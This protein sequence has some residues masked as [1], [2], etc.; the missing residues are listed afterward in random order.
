MPSPT[1]VALATTT[2]GS[3]GASSITFSS[4]PQTYTDLVV[5]ASVRSQ[6]AQNLIYYTFN[7]TSG[8]VSGR[9]LL[10]NPANSPAV[11][12]GLYDPSILQNQNG[13][14][15]STFASNE[16]YIPNYSS[17]TINKSSSVDAVQET[18]ATSNALWLQAN[19]WS[20]TAAITSI[21]ITDSLNFAQYSTATLYGIKNS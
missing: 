13:F 5:K 1:F 20:S 17:S 10:A 9:Y 2:V 19:L 11:T 15:T 18:N 6:G 21:T 4:I 3:G 14:T 16:I 7:G 12:S 8:N